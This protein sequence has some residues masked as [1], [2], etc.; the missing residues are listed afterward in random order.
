MSDRPTLRELHDAV[1]FRRRHIGPDEAQRRAMLERIGYSSLD[2][3]M[4]A[5]VPASIADREPLDVPDALSEAEALA[6]LRAKAERN[7][8]GVAMIGLG[9]HPTLTPAVIRRNLLEDPSWYTAYPPT[10]RRS[11][12]AVSRRSSTSRPW[13]RI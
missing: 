6:A 12:R 3:L 4:S 1:P 13:S 5:A 8:P 2:A 10:S 11:H 9:Y 7:R